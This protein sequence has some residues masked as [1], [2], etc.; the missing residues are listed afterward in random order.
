MFMTEDLQLDAIIRF[1]K[2]FDSVQGIVRSIKN[3]FNEFY[4]SFVKI[5]TF[6]ARD[7]SVSMNIKTQ[8]CILN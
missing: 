5:V 7:V 6:L 3:I 2:M 8:L 1:A 4:F